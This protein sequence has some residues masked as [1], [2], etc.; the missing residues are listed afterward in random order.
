MRT[1]EEAW[2]LRYPLPV[3]RGCLSLAAFCVLLLSGCGG[4]ESTISG[5]VR[6]DNKPLNRGTVTFHPVDGGAAAYGRIGADGRYEIRTGHGKGLS[7]GEYRV[8]V[9]AASEPPPDGS[10]EIPGE[11]L[12]PPRYGNL[13]E[14]DL[15]YTVKRGSNLIDIDLRRDG[16]Q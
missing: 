2:M 11:L 13:D 6:L 1:D 7:P 12:T 16:T 3:T 14:T 5:V 4:H 10:E 8:T 15:R 9:V